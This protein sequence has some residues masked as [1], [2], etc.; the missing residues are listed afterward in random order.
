MLSTSVADNRNALLAGVIVTPDADGRSGVMQVLVPPGV[1]LA[2]GLFVA[3]GAASPRAAEFQRCSDQGCLAHLDLDASDM[4]ALRRA[5]RAD[6]VYRPR[7]T[8]APV[9]FQ[10]SLMG[11]SAALAH[12]LRTGQ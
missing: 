8:T 5:A 11:F 9:R 3:I 10:A 1:H 4:Q 6:I 7:S 12:A 2:S